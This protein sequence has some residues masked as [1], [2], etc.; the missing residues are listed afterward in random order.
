MEFES[1]ITLEGVQ[2]LFVESSLRAPAANGDDQPWNTILPAIELQELIPYL[3]AD[4]G[5]ERFG[6][7]RRSV[8]LGRKSGVIPLV[9]VTLLAGSIVEIVNGHTRKFRIWTILWSYVEFPVGG[10]SIDSV[11]EVTYFAPW[12]TFGNARLGAQ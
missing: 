10:M 12:T 5:G 4:L 3:F 8:G 6:C 9:R 7:G 1:Y 11:P 2:E